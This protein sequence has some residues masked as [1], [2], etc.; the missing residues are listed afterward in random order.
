MT[1]KAAEV[2][3]QLLSGGV[4]T[5]GTPAPGAPQLALVLT[6]ALGPQ[7]VKATV[8]VGAGEGGKASGAML[9]VAVSV[10]E[11]PAVTVPVLLACVVSVL[12]CWTRKHSLAVVVLP[13][14]V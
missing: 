13:D 8:P 9:T 14:P 12:G 11:A 10:M 5:M 4:Q 7:S 1:L 2:A 6:L 3:V